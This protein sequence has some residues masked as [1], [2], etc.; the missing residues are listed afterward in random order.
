MIAQNHLGMRAYCNQICTSFPK[1]PHS[2]KLP[3]A[4][5]A[6]QQF[7]TV[8]LVF[9]LGAENHAGFIMDMYAPGEKD[10]GDILKTISSLLKKGIVGYEFLDV[11]NNPYQSFV[12]TRIGDQRLAGTRLYRQKI[13]MFTL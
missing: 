13:N 5:S 6:M 12:T 2:E 10:L 1:S 8:D 9:N 7:R 11:R 3:K 4:N